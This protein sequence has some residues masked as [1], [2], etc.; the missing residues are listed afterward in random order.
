MSP[1]NRSVFQLLKEVTFH[2]MKGCITFFLGN[3]SSISLLVSDVSRGI[4]LL[5]TCFVVA[6]YSLSY[7]NTARNGCFTFMSTIYEK[8][9][10]ARRY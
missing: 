4:F 10:L 1:G 6:E 8:Y 2:E 7:Q 3:V 9:N 5:S